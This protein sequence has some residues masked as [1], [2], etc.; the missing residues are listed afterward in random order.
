MQATFDMRPQLRRRSWNR[1]EDRNRTASTRLRNPVSIVRL[2]GPIG[3]LQLAYSNASRNWPAYNNTRPYQVL[4]GWH[5]GTHLPHSYVV[6]AR[7]KPNQ[8]CGRP[9]RI[10]DRALV[11]ARRGRLPVQ[12]LRVHSK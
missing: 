9:Q 2:P 7:Y 4:V 8:G 11:L 1:N 3:P 10:Q 5:F 6:A 12:I